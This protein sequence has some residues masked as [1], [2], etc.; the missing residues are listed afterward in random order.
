MVKIVVTAPTSKTNRLGLTQL[1]YARARSMIAVS[2]H[3]ATSIDEVTS[4]IASTTSRDV[5]F[6]EISQRECDTNHNPKLD[7]P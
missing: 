1:K 6:A 3:P 2:L 5:N 7:L 4:L